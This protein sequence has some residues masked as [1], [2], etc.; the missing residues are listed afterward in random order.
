MKRSTSFRCRAR[1]ADGGDLID[2]LVLFFAG[3]QLGIDV[4]D[5]EF[6]NALK[7]K[8]PIPDTVALVSFG[9]VADGLLDAWNGNTNRVAGLVSRGRPNGVEYLKEVSVWKFADGQFTKTHREPGSKRDFKL[10][11]V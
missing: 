2:V 6:Q 4:L 3:P 9:A 10:G 5:D 11:K 1:C 7:S 8:D